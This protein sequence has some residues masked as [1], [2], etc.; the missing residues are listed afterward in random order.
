MKKEFVPY[1]QALAL[2][3]LGFDEGCLCAYDKNEMLYHGHKTDKLFTVL[4]S[5]LSIPCAAPLY[6]QAFEW[7]LVNYGL[8]FRPDYYDEN[9]NDFSGSIH[10]LGKFSALENIGKYKS[11]EEAK[12]A[13]LNKLIEKV[14]INSK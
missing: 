9:R 1:E 4:N 8:W 2:K 10:K 13:C 6:Q 3:E 5:K 14:K 12:L 11:A 7:F